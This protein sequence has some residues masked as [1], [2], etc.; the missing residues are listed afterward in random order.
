MTQA[1]PLP[2]L[3]TLKTRCGPE[4]PSRTSRYRTASLIGVHLVVLA[5][6]AHWKVA[7]TTL[8]PVEPSEAMQ[9]LE[10][11]YVNAGFILFAIA[12]LLTAIFG[13][14]FCGWL[15]HL[16]A[17]QDLCAWILGKL[18]LRPRPVRSRFLVYIPLGAALYMFVWPTV[19]RWIDG[20][21]APSF[22]AHFM[23]DDLWRTFPGPAIALLTI[24]ID[25]ALIVWFLGAKGFCTYGCP[26]GGFFALADR[27]APVRIRVTDACEGCGHCTATCTSNVKVHQ[28]VALH[29]MVVDPGCMKCLDCVSACPKDALYVGFGK[30]PVQ[31]ARK[32]AKR[33]F[34]FSLGE[35]LTL[36]ALF[37]FALYAFRSLYDAIPF[38]LAL[39]LSV[40]TAVVSIT[41]IRA[42]RNSE[43][44]FQHLTLRRDRRWTLGGV[45]F[46]SLSAVWLTFAMHSALVQFHTREG[47][48]RVVAIQAARGMGAPVQRGEIEKTLAEFERAEA[49]GLFPDARV[50]LALAS[51]HDNLGDR[52]KAEEYLRRTLSHDE[53]KLQARFRLTDLLMMRGAREEAEQELLRLLEIEP[54]NAEAQRRLQIVR[55]SR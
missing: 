23:T 38:L 55:E 39:G 31:S 51:L 1:N 14:F 8:T 27:V 22:V 7:G 35:D 15:C 10:L 19:S 24:L 40:L 6:L 50:E 21:S 42:L 4:R 43:F 25:G 11:G 17:Y 5:H 53:S 48:R 18:R 41:A 47:E 9:T 28:E 12:I 32:P 46:A 16:V 34:D 36:V 44:T 33:T 2:P 45:V 30:L 20:R 26:Y 52:G 54:G 29:R 49:L 37:F 3:S 13:R